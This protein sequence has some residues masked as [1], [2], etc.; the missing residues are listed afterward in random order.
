VE[1]MLGVRGGGP[2]L[3]MPEV[4]AVRNGGRRDCESWSSILRGGAGDG[5]RLRIAL[6]TSID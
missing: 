4:D 2:T 3:G 1:D 6:P 5:L